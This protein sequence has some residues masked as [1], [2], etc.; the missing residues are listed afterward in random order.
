MK[1]IFLM[2]TFFSIIYSLK[3]SP[4]K[5]G[6]IL[7]VLCPHPFGMGWGWVFIVSLI[8]C[9]SAFSQ[10][11]VKYPYFFFNKTFINLDSL[12][13]ART[14]AEKAIKYEENEENI[15]VFDDTRVNIYSKKT[16]E[17]TQSFYLL[18]PENAVVVDNYIF[19]R[20]ET[21]IYIY[22]L[23]GKKLVTKNISQ[24]LNYATNLTDILAKINLHTSDIL[25]YISSDNTVK[26]IDLQTGEQK[27]LF[28]KEKVLPFDAQGENRVIPATNGVICIK[29]LETITGYKIYKYD[30]YG[31]EV[32]YKEI[33]HTKLVR[34][35]GSMLVPHREL[36]YLSQTDDF[37]IFANKPEETKQK[38]IL[39]NKSTGDTILL[40][41]TSYD[42]ISDEQNKLQRLLSFNCKSKILTLYTSDGKKL[43][44]YKFNNKLPKTDCFVRGIYC[45]EAQC[46][47]ETIFVAN[48]SI[49]SNQITISALNYDNGVQQWTQTLKP[50]EATKISN[51]QL[52]LYEYKDKI[53]LTGEERNI[54]Y[55]QIL[56]DKTGK[57]LYNINE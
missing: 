2:K 4:D 10:K 28:N 30:I 20:D 25:Y 18:N 32:F 34:K 44:E 11:H 37:I 39:L 21:N 47:K 29:D 23:Q 46:Q 43:W 52:K 26:T 14:I 49:I 3:S 27:E 12:K 24:E 42:F 45:S 54:K 53:I 57:I 5:W 31:K 8:I 15:F 40:N 6:R 16:G 17:K 41:F 48:Y 51:H 1:S 13:D 35:S 36:F 55:L 38:T 22:D 33:P 9:N 56:D 19:C 7:N 50:F